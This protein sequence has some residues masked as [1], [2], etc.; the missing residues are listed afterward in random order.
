M[1]GTTR[2]IA[3]A[4]VMALFMTMGACAPKKTS[5]S[6]GQYIDDVTITAK[7]RAAIIKD[8]LLKVTQIEVKT[9]KNTVQLS[10]FVDTPEM[11]TEAGDL[12]GKV[13]GVTTVENN[14]LV[15]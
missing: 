1:N 14:L 2:T 13:N 5:E 9:Y 6:T 11:V 10:G 15:K 4:L 8:S 7:I 12:A 3:I